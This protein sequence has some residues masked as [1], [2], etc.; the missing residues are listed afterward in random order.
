MSLLRN[1]MQTV[2][3]STIDKINHFDYRAV[4]SLPC[5]IAGK[6]LFHLKIMRHYSTIPNRQKSDMNPLHF[7]QL[8]FTKAKLFQEATFF[9]I[10]FTYLS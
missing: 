1:K 9:V 10:I 6:Y 5:T 7:L 3:D 2:S 8:F 4:H